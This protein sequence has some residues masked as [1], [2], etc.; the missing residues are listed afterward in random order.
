MNYY[1]TELLRGVGGVHSLPVCSDLGTHLVFLSLQAILLCKILFYFFDGMRMHVFAHGL[2][3]GVQALPE[4]RRGGIKG[5]CELPGVGAGSQAPVSF[6]HTLHGLA[7][8]PA[9]KASK[10]FQPRW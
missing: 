7:I 2:C 8:P 3:T 10:A 4:A 6:A 5:G 1:W 9:V